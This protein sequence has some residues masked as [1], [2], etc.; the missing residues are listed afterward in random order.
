M[1]IDRWLN[2]NTASLSGKTV[3][4]SGSTGGLG[5]EL[6]A[7]LCDLG[8]DLV[9]ID[10]N[11]SLSASHKEALEKRREGIRVTCVEAQLDSPSSVKA[12]TEKLKNLPI[13]I[14]ISNAGAYS[15]PRK[16]CESGYDNVF[17]INFVS[18]Y[19]II[20]ALL[21]T[22][23]ER[24]GRVVIVGSV[25]HRYSVSDCHDIDFSTRKSS[26]KVYGNSKR[27]LMFALT[28]K[29]LR[30]KDVG[31]AVTHPGISFTGITAHYPKWIFAVIKH[32][33]KVIFPK[34]RVA[35]LSILRGVFEDAGDYTWIGP[36]IFDV[37]GKPKKRRLR[38]SADERGY[39]AKWNA[40][41]AEDKAYAEKSLF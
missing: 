19:L 5:R 17:Q 23:R 10:R 11:P 32:P 35:C 14:F 24:G 25:A 22:L 9:L 2:K 34:P 18:P 16:I 26:A 20:D 3:A 31:F 4:I 39:F 38:I 8:A 30:E 7:Y 21:P 6:C 40:L 36:S 29:F 37:W 27:Y 41:C 13:D 28:E 15:I 33:M 1:R 12:A